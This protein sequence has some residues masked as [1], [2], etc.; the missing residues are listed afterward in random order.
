MTR[1]DRFIARMQA[2]RVLLN[3]VCERLNKTVD[4]FP[5]P[6]IELGLGNGRTFDHL[7]AKLKG[8][9][10]VVFEREV[11]AHPDSTPPA[12]DLLVGDIT[13]TGP[14]FAQRNGATAVLVH[15]DL[16]N[17]RAEYDRKLQ[18]WMPEVVR[19]LTRPDGLVITSTELSH[20][21]LIEQ[22]LPEAVVGGKY[23]VYRRR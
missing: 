4:D 22:P 11:T 1:L 13:V 18:A 15:A 14:A 17:G 7:R 2:Q 6:V 8:R 9:R 21:A 19:A 20:A 10:I 12:D 23:F 16:G 5:G 3:E